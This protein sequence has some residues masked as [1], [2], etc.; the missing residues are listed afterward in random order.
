MHGGGGDTATARPAATYVAALDGLR[1]A[2]VLGVIAFH[3]A[4]LEHR[5]GPVSGGWLGV[6]VFFT[7]SGYLITSLLLAELTGRGHIDLAGFWR[8]RVRRL[9]PA[10][11]VA[12]TVIVLTAVWWSPGGTADSVRTQAL[13]AMGG[14]ANW[15]QL[16]AHRPY[17]AGTSPSGF[18]HFWSLAVEEQFYVVWPLVLTAIGLL[19]RR[20]PERIRRTVLVVAVG[21]ITGSWWLL[22]RYSLQR[23]YLGTDARMGA[24]LLGAALA[25]VLPLGASAPAAWRRWAA[26]VAS[27]ALGVSAVLWITGGWPPRLSLGL[28]LPLQGLATVAVLASFVVAP[29]SAPARAFAWGPLAGLGR[30]SYGAYLW[31]WPLFV[32]IT[33]D[34]LHAGWLVTSFVRVAALAAATAASWVV[35]ERPVRRGLVLPRTRV[36]LPI[37]AA[38][39]AVV[40]ALAVRAI[41]PAPAWAGADGR[42]IV[43]TATV[44]PPAASAV[45]G[46]HP[47]RV[48]VVG[49]SIATSLISGPTGTLQL[50][51]GHLFDHLA[52]RGIAGAGATISGCPVVEQAF[53]ADGKVN[54]SCIDSQ[55]KR[56]PDAMAAFHPDLV[57]WYSRQ[58]AY[59]FVDDEGHTSTDRAT[60][61]A[62][63]AARLQW[64][65]ARGAH[66]LLVSPG[67]NGDGWEWNAPDGRSESMRQLDQT[68]TEVARA[69]PDVVVGLVHMEQLLCAG[70]AHGCPDRG[71]GGQR[72]RID[73]VHFL[74][75]AEDAAS[76]WLADRVAGVVLP[77]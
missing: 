23:A 51:T 75:P 70:A 68:L 3:L 15:H 24:I 60:L 63:Y 35:V 8:R 16:W 42:L 43:P 2:S 65:A 12:I 55:R 1:G 39:V 29:S 22:G 5:Q 44:A 10:A 13:S 7:L 73:G 34:R 17:A 21:G 6:D 41:A 25:T 28:V 53:V 62:R 48:L 45:P 19:L 47:T 54:R 30:V 26:P 66:V 37:A 32:L 49:D 20:H 31:H 69:H 14:V 27:A 18:E 59:P 57:V 76:A 67:P 40:A 61:E 52:A 58:E 11:L 4:S 46:H 71:P 56:L 72:Y 64:F 33:E 36:A 38:G 74:G 50:A 9:Q 77:R